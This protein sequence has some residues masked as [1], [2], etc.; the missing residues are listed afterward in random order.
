MLLVCAGLVTYA[1]IFTNG[2]VWDDAG[3][4]FFSPGAQP[5]FSLLQLFTTSG[6]HEAFYRPV[7]LTYLS[8]VGL[9]SQGNVFIIHLL[10]V[11]LHIVNAVLVFLLFK[12]F[13]KETG[14]L[15]LALIFIVHPINVE[16]VTYMSAVGNVL[17]FT[18]GILG[19]HVLIRSRIRWHHSLFS[20]ILVLLSLLTN[21]TG[22]VWAGIVLAYI[23]L[24]KKVQIW[25]ALIFL[26]SSVG[27]Y[28]LL[29]IGVGQTLIH[30]AGYVPIAHLTFI[31]RM[32]T[33][34]KILLFYL[35]TFFYPGYLSIAQH[36]VVR[37]INFPDFVFPFILDTLFLAGIIAGGMYLYRRHARLL[38]A[39]LFFLFWFLIS[40]TLYLQIIPLDMTVADRWFYTPIIGMLGMI[41]VVSQT[42]KVKPNLRIGGTILLIGIIIGFSIRS[43]V[44]NTDWRDGLTLFSHDIQ[45]NPDSFDIHVKLAAELSRAGRYDEALAHARRAVALEP[46]DITSLGTVATLLLQRKQ[47][48]EAVGYLQQL[49]TYDADNYNGFTNLSYAFLRM[50]D[51]NSA[52]TYAL[53]GLERY[54]ED[55]SLK[56]FLSIAEY[57]L[58]D[59]Q[60]AVNDAAF[61][62]SALQNE[63][64][65]YVYTQIM[66]KQQVNVD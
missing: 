13:L 63:N 40:I 31:E 29:R 61:A 44:R 17:A 65:R 38:V 51:N 12:K 19:L 24:F 25:N 16:A 58:G 53:R 39:Y 9:L 56:L 11:S 48:T 27:I 18:F 3:W 41:G 57:R 37:S 50:N 35:Q 36:W 42:V 46:D 54:K 52:K 22:I 34:P 47:L 64:S 49:L 4:M 1:N 33:M 20:G 7:F 28:A 59:W 32:Y 8:L 26:I 62:H 14:A 66:N 45:I 6:Q 23:F 5:H 2:L 30:T 15:F 10:Q 55:P 60:S 43:I 21:E